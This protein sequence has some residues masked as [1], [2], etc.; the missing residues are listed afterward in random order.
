MRRRLKIGKMRIEI[1]YF[2]V[3][4]VLALLFSVSVILYAFTHYYGTPYFYTLIFVAVMGFIVPVG[5]YV[6]YKYTLLQNKEYYFPQFLKDL[7]DGTRAGLSLPQAVMNVSKIN[8]GALTDDVRRLAMYISWGVPFDE[9]IKRFAERTGS[10]MIQSSVAL[11]VE[12][13]T[14]GGGIADILDTMAEDAGKMHSLKEERKTKFSGFISTI[15]SVYVIFLIISVVLITTLLPEIPTMPSFGALQGGAST[16]LFGVTNSEPIPEDE[17]RAIFFHLAIIE[18]VFAGLLAGIVGEGSVAAGMK[19]A[20][21]LIFIGVAVF[22][23]FVPEPDPV[24]RVAGAISKLPVNVDASIF[25][26]RYFLDHSVTAGDV[27][28]AVLERWNKQNIPQLSSVVRVRF[29]ESLDG[30]GPCERGD[31]QVLPDAII[32]NR[33]TYVTFSVKTDPTEGVYIVYVS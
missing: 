31:I 13:Y 1:S 25:V 11:I 20:I 14:A 26:G 12:A 2:S 21:I 6:Y 7:A 33:P 29:A 10:K 27:S 15:Y 32:V 16:G 4:F 22:Q 18:A 23:I 28:E 24:D 30:C 3:T 5:G 9:A 19:H 8:Y 17:L